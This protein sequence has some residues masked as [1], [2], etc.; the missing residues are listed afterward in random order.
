MNV[1]IHGFEVD[2]H[3]PGTNLI[4]ELDGFGYHASAKAF[5]ADRLRDAELL[6]AGYRVVRITYRQL[7]REPKAVAR[8]LKA[9]LACPP[10]APP[11]PHSAARH[12][13]P[14]GRP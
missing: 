14:A 11:S 8:R 3:W 4:V 12:P 9:L 7:T 2:A 10:P 13:A 6:L 5:E 1:M